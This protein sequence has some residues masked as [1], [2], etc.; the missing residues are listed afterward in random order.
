MNTTTVSVDLA[1][2]VFAVC[3]G[4]AHDHGGKI[5]VFNRVELLA[6]LKT[7][8]AGTRIAM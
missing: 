3:V 2:Q 4:D 7:L 5:T 1:K 6:L 8:P